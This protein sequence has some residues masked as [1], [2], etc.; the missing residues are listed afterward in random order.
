MVDG[1]VWVVKRVV[2]NIVYGLKCD[3]CCAALSECVCM[4]VC[5]FA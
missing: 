3:K 2:R 4:S 1:I 5:E